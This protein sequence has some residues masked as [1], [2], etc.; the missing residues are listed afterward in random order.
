MKTIIAVKFNSLIIC[1]LK[2]MWY[3]YNF[4]RKMI[5]LKQSII[6]FPIHVNI[7]LFQVFL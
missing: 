3:K 1:N 5:L 6:L 4:R 7:K 2:V